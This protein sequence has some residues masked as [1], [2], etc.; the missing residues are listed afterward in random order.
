L[1]LSNPAPDLTLS[2]PAPDLT[3]SN[4]ASAMLSAA[5]EAVQF[6]NPFLMSLFASFTDEIYATAMN[7]VN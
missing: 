3:L 1:T 4:L 7:F 2:N 5:L 6:S